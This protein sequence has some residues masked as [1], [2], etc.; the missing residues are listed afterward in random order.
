MQAESYILAEAEYFQ[1]FHCLASKCTDGCCH[2][3][4]INIDRAHYNRIRSVKKSPELARLVEEGIQR[5][6]RSVSP[7]SYA[8][9][10][11]REDGTCFFLDENSLCMLQREYGP[12]ILPKVCRIFPRRVRILGNL[13]EKSCTPSCEEVVNRLWELPDKLKFICGPAVYGETGGLFDLPPEQPA[14]N[15]NLLEIQS[16]CIDIL[17][18]REYSLDDRVILLGIAL[19]SLAANAGTDDDGVIEAWLKRYDALSSGNDFQFTL[20][21]FP[22]AA[23]MAFANNTMI[24]KRVSHIE[25]AESQALVKQILEKLHLETNDEGQSRINTRD[26]LATKRALEEFLAGKEYLLENVIVNQWFYDS[27]PFGPK[28]VWRGYLRFVILYSL[29]KF[30]LA[31]GISEVTRENITRTITLWARILPHSATVLDALVEQMIQSKS[32]TM[33]HLAILLKD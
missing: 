23:D 14:I 6:K 26:Y 10:R 2:S 33:A 27:L 32:D 25:L 1:D 3:W 17:Q 21:S 22:R 28:G 16:L 15:R 24:I 11:L 9:M 12:S 31:G 30:M 13:V 8:K 18:N 5:D 19:D 7:Q 29:L 20:D 4:R